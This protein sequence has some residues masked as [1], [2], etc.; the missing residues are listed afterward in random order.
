MKI[1]ENIE[2]ILNGEIIIDYTSSI[3]KH[4]HDQGLL[5]DKCTGCG[6]KEW[7]GELLSLE[8]DHVDGNNKNNKKENLKLLCPNCHSITPTYRSKK[9]KMNKPSLKDDQILEEIKKGG[10]VKNI[11]NR[12]KL[13]ESGG[14]YKRIYRICEKNNIPKPKKVFD[15]IFINEYKKLKSEFIKI[16]LKSTPKPDLTLKEMENIIRRYKNE[17]KIKNLQLEIN[18]ITNSKINF[19]KKGWQVQVAKILNI[20]PQAVKQWMVREMPDFY[21]NCWSHKDNNNN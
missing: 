20:V 6:I 1:K 13:D 2:K 14:N 21:K 17:E 16:P 12:L 19:N 9:L 7:K 18:E 15:D 4:I 8:I 5:G 10:N 3:R 11:L